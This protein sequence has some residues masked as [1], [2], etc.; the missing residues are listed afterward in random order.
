MVYLLCTQALALVG[1]LLAVAWLPPRN[2]SRELGSEESAQILR[3][4]IH[5]VSSPPARAGVTADR[6]PPGPAAWV[7]GAIAVCVLF[8]M[9]QFAIRVLGAQWRLRQD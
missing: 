9:R 3:S 6:R 4:Q 5:L 8:L 1:M 2:S 7:F